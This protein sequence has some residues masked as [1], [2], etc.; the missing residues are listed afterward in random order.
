MN[1]K[2]CNFT[3][4]KFTIYMSQKKKKSS[5]PSLKQQIIQ[6]FSDLPD[7]S[8]N[9][10]QVCGKL[11]IQDKS[12]RSA[13]L[14][15]LEVLTSEEMLVETGR[16]MYKFNPLKIE[17][18]VVHAS[19]ITGR[20]EMKQT[21]KA[22][23]I[24]EDSDEDILIEP[25]NVNHALDGDIVRVH[26][27][28]KRSGRKTEGQI[29]EIIERKRTKFVGVISIGRKM[30]FLTPDDQRIPLDI[31]IL[32][33]DLAG[34]KSGMKAIAEMTDWPE[35]SNNPFGRVVNV[36]G[37][38]G[39]NEVEMKSILASNDFPLDFE[40]NT[41]NEADKI[42]DTI[43]NEEI[44]RRRDFRD[45]FTITIDPDDAK[46][47]DDA[48]SVKQIENGNFE[49]GIHIA[50]VSYYVSPGSSFDKEAYIRGTS[51]YLVDRVIPMLPERLSNHLCSLRPGEEK[52]CF[53]AV[54]EMDLQGNVSNEWFGK[55]I[56]L[57][58]IRFN[59]EEVQNIIEGGDH[60]K[61]DEIIRLHTI[62]TSLRAKRFEKGAI[63]FRSREIKFILDEKGIPV[64]AMVKEQKESNHLVE[65]FMLLANRK[66]TEWVN[67]HYGKKIKEAPLFVYRI[68]DE[69]SPERLQNFADFL[70]KL[71][72]RLDTSSR[73]RISSSMNS[74]L[75]NISGKAEENMIETIAV[76]TMAKALYSADN[77][78]HYGLGFS[79]YTHFTSPIRRYPDLM[80]HRL[81]NN[82]L[83]GKTPEMSYNEL[84]EAC[85]HC[86]EMEKKAA[87]AERESVKLKQVEYMAERLGEN[88]SGVVSGVSKWG[89]FVEIDEIKAEG[90]VRMS[91]MN[92]DFFYLDEENYSV[93]G[94]RTGQEIRLGDRVNI[95]LKAVDLPKKQ[96][97]LIL[98]SH[99][100]QGRE[101]ATNL[102]FNPEK[103]TVSKQ[104]STKT[105]GS[106]K[107]LEG[108]DVWNNIL[109]L[110]LKNMRSRT[111]FRRLSLKKAVWAEH[112]SFKNVKVNYLLI[113]FF[114]LMI[115]SVLS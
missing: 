25:N 39:N 91:S 36:L 40:M 17:K 100:P 10:K 63:N 45:E 86:S 8:F 82:H 26:L 28:P 52:L 22:Y 108:D 32:P 84:E 99:V 102:I 5:Q 97:D 9:Y 7:K 44:M 92:H 42:S 96:M 3:T 89:I 18:Q 79:Y 19:N 34:A 29:I 27:F 74:L 105:H 111:H 69:P 83:S 4:I 115:P 48:I 94:Q 64:K 38:P 14:S 30:A 60:E 56:I 112:G 101:N 68:H 77:I 81:L 61:R 107:D 85:K 11:G 13:V 76:R 67:L 70:V 72:Y 2:V 103:A 53:S 109:Y 33:E 20:V 35:K 57:S 98:V 106:K 114:V 87:D 73:K 71:G 65:E 55:T 1:I 41:L 80:V 15:M 37:M 62:A 58:D 24:T 110:F 50:D 54:F 23:I 78:G 66:V 6:F 47:F 21:G 46:D 88:F 59:Y 90:L 104:R 43:S 113:I 75:D 12:K 49:I 93:I 51:I 95:L 16:G 31:M